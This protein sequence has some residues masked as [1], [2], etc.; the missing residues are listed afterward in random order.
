MLR[1]GKNITIAMKNTNG[2]L[3]KNHLI[4]CPSIVKVWF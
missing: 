2:S 1:P 3:N 4:I